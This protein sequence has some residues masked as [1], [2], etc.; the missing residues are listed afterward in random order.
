MNQPIP[1]PVTEK[2]S[3]WDPFPEPNTIPTGWNLSELMQKLGLDFDEMVQL[4]E[5]QQTTIP[6]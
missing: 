1:F 4:I 3:I 2:I 5:Q 6:D